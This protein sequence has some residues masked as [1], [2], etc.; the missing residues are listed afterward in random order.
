M[1]L[2]SWL[3]NAAV[4]LTA[5]VINPGT[6]QS[7]YNDPQLAARMGAPA[8]A[9]TA[10]QGDPFLRGALQGMA[11]LR[12]NYVSRPISTAFL[13][14]GL[15][16]EKPLDQ[17][18][19]LL[20]NS[21]SWA[22]SWDAAQHISPGQALGL[23]PDKG[24]YSA[25]VNSPLTYYKP[26][27]ALLPQGFSALPQSQQETY[28]QQAGMP[29]VGNQFIE[30]KRQDSAMF[31]YGSGA[32]DFAFSW[33]ADP[34]ILGGKVLGR[35]RNTMVALPEEGSTLS[36]ILN[37]TVTPLTRPVPT[38]GQRLV[39]GLGA[40]LT[41]N[42]TL[43]RNPQAGWTGADIQNLV[44][45]S[46]FG[47]IQDYLWENR[48]NPQLLNNLQMARRSAMGPR[49]GAVVS[50]LQSPEEINL[51]LRSGMGDVAA[52][53]ELEQK[54]ALAMGIIEQNEARL[55]TLNLDRA[56]NSRNAYAAALIDQRMSQVQAAI[57]A[58][59]PMTQRYG[60][61]LDHYGELDNMRDTAF[62]MARAEG[63]QI[64]QNAYTAGAG[65]TP[66]AGTRI[67][68][69]LAKSRI[70]STYFQTPMTVIR[71][72]G[73][74]KPSGWMN[75]NDLDQDS[76]NELRGYLARIPN[77]TPQARQDTVNQYIQAADEG[78]RL[79]I[80][81]NLGKL[82]MA[83]VAAKYGL[84]PE[85][86]EALYN[87][88][89]QRLGVLQDNLRQYATARIQ[90]QAGGPQ[91]RV[92]AFTDAG[93]AVNIH[94]NLV[95]RLINSHIMPDL[96][97]YGQ[98]LSRHSGPLEAL[99]VRAGGAA[100]AVTAG[101]DFFQHLWKFGTLL[102]LGY[103]PRVLGDDLSGQMARLGM[104]SMA[105]RAGFGAK[106]LATNM[107]TMMLKPYYQ[108][109]AETKRIGLEY[110]M[111]E[112][113]ALQADI[114]K[115][116]AVHDM[117]VKAGSKAYNKAQGGL[118]AAQN[119]LDNA[120]KAMA[121]AQRISSLEQLVSQRQAVAAATPL[122]EGLV[123]A[124]R[125][126]RLSD[127]QEHLSWLES[128]R[129]AMQA[130]RQAA[131]DA[132]A[133][134]RQGDQMLKINGITLPGALQG[135]RGQYFQQLLSPDDSLANVFNTNRQ[136][137]HGHLMRSWD[138]GA[139]Q[140]Y[141]PA[142][143]NLHA[144]AWSH[145]I[146]AQ[147]AQDTAA[148]RVLEEVA[149]GFTPDESIASMQSWLRTAPGQS[150]RA[151]LGLKN[152]SDEQIAG[153]IASD[154]HEMVPLPLIAQK[155]LEADGVTPGFLKA[156]IPNVMQ[157]PDA[158]A[159]GLGEN[160]TLLR[161]H[162]VLDRLI[163]HWFDGVAEIPAKS[164]SR[165]PLF[166]Q[167]Y[168]GH[169]HALMQQ[170]AS[171]GVVHTADDAEYIAETSRRLALKDTKKLV[172][173]IAHKS[174]A[175]AALHFIAPFFSATAEG[176]QRWARIIADR[177]EVAGYAGKF[178]NVPLAL[179]NAQNADGFNIT[180]DGQ[181]WDPTQN[182]MVDAPMSDRFI[183]ARMPSFLTKPGTGWLATTPGIGSFLGVP[184]HAGAQGDIKLSQESMNLVL[185]GDPWFNPGQGPL[186]TIPVN[187]FVKDKPSDALLARQLG[188][189][190][191]GPS[192]NPTF[193]GRLVDQFAPSTIKDF[194]SA[195]NTSD[196][197]Y[198]Q[199][200]LQILQQAAYEHENFGAKMPTAS[201]IAARV[202]NYWLFSAA[203]AFLGPVS[204]QKSSDPYA[205]YRQQYNLLLR[206][207]PKTADQEY[208][209]RYGESHFVFAQ[210]LSK[211]LS[212]APATLQ[213]VKLEQKYGDLI[214]QHPDLAPLII[215][216][217]GNGPFSPEA[218]TYELNNPLVPG[219][220]EMMRTKL[221]AEQAMAENQ[222][223]LGWA[224]YT[225][226]LNGLTAQLVSR[227][228][229]SFDQ[230]GAEDLRAAKGAVIKMLGEP[231]S[232][233]G[234]ANPFYNDAWSKDYSSY[235]RLKSDRTVLGLQQLVQ[236]KTLMSDPNRTDLHVLQQYL[237]VRQQF[238]GALAERKAGGGSDNMTTL[239]GSNDD[240]K[241]QWL[242]TIGGL[243][244]A[245][246]NF[247]NLYHRYLSKDLGVDALTPDMQ[248]Q[249]DAF[250]QQQQLINQGA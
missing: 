54:N 110:N 146:N 196:T 139:V 65:R 49:F 95:S 155:A 159:P 172:F 34:V 224:Q 25:A 44:Q 165:H 80:L 52:K 193:Q 168:E 136:M 236:D 160:Y 46:N 197:R 72:F 171:Q 150:Y 239:N 225:G 102:R 17:Q 204:G 143:E 7:Q 6:P 189:L 14:A 27:D 199:I 178:F 133:K 55:S 173:D 138:H 192:N 85:Y 100:D 131:I 176:W 38:L 228:L 227:G 106:N 177:P 111:Q 140:V 230:K 211:N 243:I 24:E 231:L 214:A 167:L 151:R 63:R 26:P 215:G 13:E 113:L 78:E 218:Y 101:A 182:K 29:A 163:Q 77:M 153:S 47:K 220:S 212:G 222:K 170:E 181:V 66:L 53:A 68:A 109:A 244:E 240:L 42:G 188:V 152:I 103:I 246:V 15:L 64:A 88:D 35:A 147:F 37:P 226:F 234:T 216:P 4:W 156:A 157:R 61:I 94:P 198:Q 117:Y 187:E 31:K 229:T 112:A 82:G 127:M 164:W 242:Q 28:L 161:Y 87:E 190:P 125:L 203:S 132:Q 40:K 107:S 20:F 60:Q 119:A 120:N 250:N 233:Q 108:A 208:L 104:A 174:D 184:L 19:N 69:A 223:R 116:E 175:M 18:G 114:A 97:R 185:A 30:N 135:T 84:K 130:E 56:T 186:V 200:K 99:Q 145:I 48:A 57:D 237:A 3:N 10:A 137:I 194:L 32:A 90:Q 79:N 16:S 126:Q 39:G 209:S 2:G 58:N 50:T 11:Y 249:L 71:S 213:A 205:F 241:S 1:G 121:P 23:N 118:K 59:L 70:A 21:N 247:G 149:K 12:N 221:T 195:Y 183:V 219:G 154:V 248:A 83:K 232:P 217:E 76:I 51:F 238:A 92:D 202:R 169:A 8:Q 36:K 162:R 86:G 91:V 122:G 128:E 206:T 207:N 33:E 9:E 43:F 75:I 81:E 210:S 245:D 73:S 89:R 144:N 141:A 148:R 98:V 123:P 166:N 45:S 201:Q 158:I 115:E 93:G 191:F 142:N 22:K 105:L 129:E 62:T 134:V 5:N 180:A 41:P 235:D 124:A 179:G 74:Y 96:D 67:G